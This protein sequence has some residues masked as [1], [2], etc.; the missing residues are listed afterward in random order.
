[1]SVALQGADSPPQMCGLAQ[2]LHWSELST[3]PLH[4]ELV[5]LPTPWLLQVPPGAPTLLHVAAP[6]VLTLHVCVLVQQAYDVPAPL[7]YV[8]PLG[9]IDAPA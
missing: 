6:A 8:V 7:Q 3:W 5:Q 9:H 2:A 4:R 1:M